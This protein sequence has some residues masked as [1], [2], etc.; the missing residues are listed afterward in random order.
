MF[1]TAL[2]LLHTPSSQISFTVPPPHTE[3][4]QDQLHAFTSQALQKKMGGKNFPQ[5]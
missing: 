5:L 4:K 2:N 1:F 3:L